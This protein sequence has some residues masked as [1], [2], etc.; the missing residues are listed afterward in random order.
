MIQLTLTLKMTTAQVV[1]TSV[2]VNNNSSIQDYVNLHGRSN[3][4]YEFDSYL[5]DPEMQTLRSVYLEFEKLDAWLTVKKESRLLCFFFD[6][7][8][9]KPTQRLK[10]TE[11]SRMRTSTKSK[12]DV[13]FRHF[14]VFAHECCRS[15]LLL[16]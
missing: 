8:N 1:K 2:T 5:N 14:L 13:I 16:V 3:S 4:I 6:M 10:Q 9:T 11:F 7:F 15:N 12:S